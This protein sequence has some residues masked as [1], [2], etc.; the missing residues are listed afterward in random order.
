MRWIPLIIEDKPLG[1]STAR[2]MLTGAL[3][4]HTLKLGRHYA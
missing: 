3:S 1:S 2:A 4:T